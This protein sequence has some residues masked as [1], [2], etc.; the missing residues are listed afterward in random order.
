MYKTSTYIFIHICILHIC[1][2]TLQ[3]IQGGFLIV[4]RVRLVLQKK[5][6]IGLSSLLNKVFLKKYK[7]TWFEEIWLH[8]YDKNIFPNL[9]TDFH[10]FKLPQ[11]GNKVQINSA[12]VGDAPTLSRKFMW[13]WAWNWK[14]WL[15]K[16]LI[17]ELYCPFPQ[18]LWFPPHLTPHLLRMR[19]KKKKRVL[20]N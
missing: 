7:H 3:Y 16:P 15:P 18:R 8:L 4:F 20:L 9:V 5:R 17:L 6:I 11:E 2:Y 10:I 1:I 19:F 14:L 12:D 13:N